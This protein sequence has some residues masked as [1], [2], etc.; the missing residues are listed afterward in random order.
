[1]Y[2]TASLLYNF[3][4]CPH[5]VWRD[6]Y[7][8]QDERVEEE[9]S[10]VKLLWEKGVNHEEKIMAK[11]GEYLD[12]GKG[13]LDERF[14][15]TLKALNDGV[16]LIYQGV[17]K[18]DNLLGIPDLLKRLPDGSY[19]TIDIKSGM[20]LEGADE[21]NGDEGKPKKHYAVQLCLYNEVLDRLGFSKSKTGKIL[22]IDGVETLYELD[23][24]MGAKSKTTWWAGRDLNPHFIAETRF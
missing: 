20:A 24:M 6:I 2:I 9:N 18:H 17:I 23:A 21:E 12:L 4:Q 5:R 11:I 19:I 15:K 1:M 14:E 16:P 22:D 3:I 7:G 13:S 8:P 10:F